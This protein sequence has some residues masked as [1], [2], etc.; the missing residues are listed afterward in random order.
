MEIIEQ[1]WQALIS[2][3]YGTVQINTLHPR[4]MNSKNILFNLIESVLF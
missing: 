4:S 1:I 2:I 3:E